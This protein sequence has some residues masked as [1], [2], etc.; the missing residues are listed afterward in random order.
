MTQWI[1]EKKR[2][3]TDESYKDGTALGRKLQKHEAF[4]AELKANADRLDSINKVQ[5]LAHF[6]Y[7]AEFLFID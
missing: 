6:S 5:T 3:A 2:I 1:V 7:R 4:E